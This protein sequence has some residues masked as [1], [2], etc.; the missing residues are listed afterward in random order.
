MIGNPKP[1][2]LLT[3]GPLKADVIHYITGQTVIAVPGVNS[4]KHLKETLEYLQSQGTTKVM[5][6]FDMDYLKNP[7]VRDGYPSWMQD[8][9]DEVDEDDEDLFDDEDEDYDEDALY[10]ERREQ[11]LF[12]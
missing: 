7:H 6:C 9:D 3:E 4:L 12:G 2:V 10:D 8:D 11:E 5:T 1:T